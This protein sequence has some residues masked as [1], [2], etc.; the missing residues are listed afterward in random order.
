MMKR[1]LIYL[2]L[3][4]ILT[5]SAFSQSSTG[6]VFLLIPTSSSLNGMGELGVGLPYDQPD[7][8][9]FNPANGIYGTRG[10]GIYGTMHQT[11]WPPGL[12]GDMSL[13]YKFLG[14]SLIPEK[15]PF[16]LVLHHQRT[17]L[18]AGTQTRT[19]SKGNV[20][21]TSSTWFSVK[22]YTLAGR[23]TRQIGP[24]QW[25]VSAGFSGKRVVQH[26]A[27]DEFMPPG[28]NGT[29]YNTFYDGGFLLSAQWRQRLNPG[30]LLKLRPGLGISIMNMGDNIKFGA[31]DPS[32]RL[33]RAGI[34]L[35]GELITASYGQM[36][37]FKWGHAASDI[38]ANPRYPGDPITYQ[39][40]LGDINIYDHVLRGEYDENPVEV[41]AGKSF[42]LFDAYT[43]REGERSAPGF[44][45]PVYE[46]GYGLNSRGM[47]RL[48]QR[49]ATWPALDM[50]NRHL[51]LRYDVSRWTS[52]SDSDPI[53]NTEFEAFTVTLHNLGPGSREGSGKYDALLPEIPVELVTGLSYSGMYPTNFDSD[54]RLDPQYERG[55][56][57]GLE[58][59]IS[60]TIV[61]FSFSQM[62]S[63]FINVDS[64]GWFTMRY[65]IH[66][67]YNYV[68]LYGLKPF[69][70]TRWLSFLIGP[71]ISACV[72]REISIFDEEMGF[73]P[74][75]ELN[76]GLTGAAQVKLT[77]AAAVRLSYYYGF[78]DI[79]DDLTN[80][81]YLRLGSFQANLVVSL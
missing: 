5:T 36:I 32:P 13:D 49:F 68:N 67:R 21:G 53:A 22:A 25:D 43:Y 69:A 35:A 40:G 20:I 80:Q 30:A 58:T 14:V 2:A 17:F 57:I 27:D 74:T 73:E 39:S 45:N 31:E 11:R 6:G 76:A 77:D 15:Y 56:T 62:G 26:L 52:G 51:T 75:H 54:D 37:A 55:Y 78:R 65:R 4:S 38:L 42:T 28:I 3:A 23:Y 59:K 41:T 16:Q 19:D 50:I 7:A 18:D 44:N 66:D 1:T 10:V 46:S 34:S 61:G 47:I 48:L 12:A 70:P 72:G 64:L 33:A 79:E 63:S 24:V 8:A 71:Q 9:Y 60:S 81:G 29:A